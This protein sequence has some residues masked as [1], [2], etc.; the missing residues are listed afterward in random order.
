MALKINKGKLLQTKFLLAT[1]YY[2]A[3]ADKKNY[4]R[5]LTE[6]LEAGDILPERRLNNVIAK[7]RAFRHL[8]NEVLQ[9]DCGFRGALGA[10]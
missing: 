7:R 4:D 5:L 9:E 6:I 1:R 10:S 8:H 2:C 3:K